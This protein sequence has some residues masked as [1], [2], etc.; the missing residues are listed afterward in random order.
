MEK[1]Q[2]W[3]IPNESKAYLDYNISEEETLGVPTY[4]VDMC[5]SWLF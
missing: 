5:V 4:R 2:G 3:R 1:K